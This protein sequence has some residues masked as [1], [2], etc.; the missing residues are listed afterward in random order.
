MHK[1]ISLIVSATLLSL[2]LVG[3]G[4]AS[5]TV[6]HKTYSPSGMTAIVKGH[7]N[8]KKGDL[9]SKRRKS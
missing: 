8:Q 4:K 7:S 5:L 3:C 2:V 1:K 9:S 6:A